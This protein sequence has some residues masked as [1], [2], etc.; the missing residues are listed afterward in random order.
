MQRRL[1]TPQFLIPVVLGAGLIWLWPAEYDHTSG[2]NQEGVG[3]AFKTIERQNSAKFTAAHAN[4]GDLNSQAM[5][6]RIGVIK[7]ERALWENT[8]PD[9]G[10]PIDSNGH[11]I[12]SE[13]IKQRF[14][15]WL[16]ATNDMS[17]EQLL[18]LMTNDIQIHLKEPA[19]GEAVTL[20]HQYINYLKMAQAGI[21]E[22]AGLEDPVARFDW[23]KSMRRA[24]LGTRVVQAFFGKDEAL[25]EARLAYLNQTNHER[26]HQSPKWQKRL[27][28]L[29]NQNIALTT[30]EDLEAQQRLNAL[31]ERRRRWDERVSAYQAFYIAWNASGQ[32][33]ESLNEYKKQHFTEREQKRL[34]LVSL[35]VN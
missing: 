3:V 22:A 29:G 21:E 34:G 15:Y 4:R 17:D 32:S 9:G 25:T 33:E 28:R 16:M 6:E 20:L 13:A 7:E 27:H 12:I 10:Y 5:H 19:L 11:L 23:I 30:H 24:W 8:S 1:L 31:Q 18:T 35:D 26:S 14:H 2:S